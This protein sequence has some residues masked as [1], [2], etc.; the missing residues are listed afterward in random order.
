[1]SWYS[2]ECLIHPKLPGRVSCPHHHPHHRP[3]HRYYLPSPLKMPDLPQ[4]LKESGFR[5]D[6][7]WH[8]CLCSKPTFFRLW[9]WATWEIHLS[10]W[11]PLM[12]P[13]LIDFIACKCCSWAS[14]RLCWAPN[15]CIKTAPLHLL[16]VGTDRKRGRTPVK[17]N[18]PGCQDSGL[19]SDTPVLWLLC[20]SISSFS[21]IPSKVFW[22]RTPRPQGSCQVLCNC[23]DR[24]YKAQ[25]TLIDTIFLTFM[26][27]QTQVLKP[28]K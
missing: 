9:L 19:T 16:W 23:V 11:C 28:S 13:V 10:L 25:I 15:S 27:C 17:R 24:S 5:F 4:R 7:A 3:H 2:E 6:F 1:M 12:S 22:V 21:F 8:R 14:H 26:M 18:N 20:G